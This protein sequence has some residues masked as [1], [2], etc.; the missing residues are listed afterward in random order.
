MGYDREEGNRQKAFS[1]RAFFLG[2][3]QLAAFGVL[4]S[5]LYYLQVLEAD[6]YVLLSDE[7]RINYRLVP[8]LRGNIVDRF[9]QVLAS[10]RENLQIVVVPEETPDLKKTLT[11]LNE[12]VSLSDA[13]QVKV[14]SRASRQ[15]SFVPITVMENISWQQF[16]QVN[17]HSPN[18]PG[19][20]PQMGATRQ[21]RYGTNLGHVI[22][23][24]ATANEQ[25][26]DGDPLLLMPGFHIGKN[27]VEKTHDL[28][29]R[30]QAGSLK[31]E[32]NA[33][34]RVIRKLD[35]SPPTPGAETVLTLDIEVQRFA[36]ERLK[37]ESAAAVV[38]DVNNGE[39][40]ALASSPGFDPNEFVGGIGHEQ[41]G[42]L[43]KDPYKPLMN[44]ALRGQYP[45]GST[46]KMVVALAALEHGV[47]K[48][49]ETVR[50]YGRYNLG[51]H[52]F[53][54]WKRGGHGRMNLHNGIKQSC[55]VYFYEVA[56]R[57]GIDKIAE[58]GEKLGLGQSL[59]FDLYGA[60]AGVMPNSGWKR[61]VIGE[62]WYPGETLVAGIGQ[63]YVLTTPLQLAVMTARIA[64]GGYAV[65]PRIVRSAGD[66]LL[67][68]DTAPR[69][70]INP[71]HLKII[72]AAM[73][74]VVNESRGTAG[75]SKFD[76]EGIKMAGKTGTSQVRRITKAERA[77]GILKNEQLPWN[78]RDHALFVAFTPVDKPRY[79]ISVIVE[80]G[81]GGSKAA[82]PVA[83]DILLKVLEREPS[84]K[85]AYG[86]SAETKAAASVSQ[87]QKVT[88]REDRS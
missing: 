44:K 41:W 54:C 20:V 47:I 60:K 68:P 48:R 28:D 34:G 51:S 59:G 71:E 64:N 69:L 12:I 1:R 13:D 62:P 14:T 43:I 40:L 18:L 76:F 32:V 72:Q 50:C 57:L 83:K 10:N 7:N 70:D 31:V 8:P 39:V 36:M 49:N 25:E 55:D 82:A 24:V 81:G 35:T 15:R 67:I 22:G 16:S 56:R 33:G 52:A 38:M 66:A 37:D 61:G 78:R 45:P 46:F 73:N 74:G 77:R 6:Q 17:V 29:L 75:R 9:G 65:E 87:D 79:A 42:K 19:V 21:Y 26:V 53:H 88:E 11:K 23:Y 30:G 80:H 85:P 2:A 27:G 5:R 4:G 63:G 86:P 3:S 84:L 58:M